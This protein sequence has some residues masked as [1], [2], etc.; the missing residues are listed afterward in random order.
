MAELT[1]ES[2]PVL[3]VASVGGD[4]A[5]NAEVVSAGDKFRIAISATKGPRVLGSAGMRCPRGPRR[6]G[7][8]CTNCHVEAERRREAGT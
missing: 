5:L 7:R 1:R 2:E 4:R 8:E 6:L 3:V